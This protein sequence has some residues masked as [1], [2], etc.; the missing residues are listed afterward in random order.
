MI[1]QLCQLRQICLLLPLSQTLHSS[2]KSE[3][4]FTAEDPYQ[5]PYYPRIKSTR[6][7]TISKPELKFNNNVR[8]L[9]ASSGAL[10]QTFDSVTRANHILKQSWLMFFVVKHLPNRA[11]KCPEALWED[12]K[13]KKKKKP[14]L[15][16]DDGVWTNIIQQKINKKNP[17]EDMAALAERIKASVKMTSCT[18]PVPHSFCVLT[19]THIHTNG[20]KAEWLFFLSPPCFLKAETPPRRW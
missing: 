16:G 6:N 1:C 2:T 17:L 14:L 18:S 10:I 15:D 19:R 5:R 12:E 8:Q 13:K 11:W 4:L 7:K 20:G 9:I 3:R